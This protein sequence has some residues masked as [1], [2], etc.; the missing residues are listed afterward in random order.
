MIKRI[1]YLKSCLVLLLKE[2]RTGRVDGET[3]A[4]AWIHFS[5]TWQLRFFCFQSSGIMADTSRI[6]CSCL[7]FYILRIYLLAGYFCLFFPPLW[8]PLKLFSILELSK[9]VY[10]YV[11]SWFFFLYYFLD[12]TVSGNDPYYELKKKM[13]DIKLSFSEFSGEKTLLSQATLFGRKS[14]VGETEHSIETE[15]GK[16]APKRIFWEFLGWRFS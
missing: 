1:E 10:L 9:C 4:F 7:M 14:P 12:K 5:N 2:G 8:K 11:E 16:C 13:F 6:L 15:S 3:Q